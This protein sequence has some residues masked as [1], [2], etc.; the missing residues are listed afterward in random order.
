MSEED[1]EFVVVKY[2][3][4]IELGRL[5]HGYDPNTLFSIIRHFHTAPLAVIDQGNSKHHV[6]V[7]HSYPKNKYCVDLKA[8]LFDPTGKTI[9]DPT[10]TS[11]NT[12]IDSTKFQ[13]T[14][15]SFSECYLLVADAPK[16]AQAAVFD[17]DS[18]F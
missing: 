14:W 11:I 8:S 10:T 7:N 16:E 1:E 3:E 12:I 15:G 18:T 4:K 9:I 17:V 2:A 6:I 5:S 13:C